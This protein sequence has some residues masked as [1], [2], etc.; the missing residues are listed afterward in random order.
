MYNYCQ[1]A[2]TEYLLWCYN[3]LD[4]VYYIAVFQTIMPAFSHPELKRVCDQLVK[5][6]NRGT[7]AH[8]K[9]CDKLIS[10]VKSDTITSGDVSAVLAH[11]LMPTIVGFL[12]TCNDMVLLD[13]IQ[14]FIEMT[15]ACMKLGKDTGDYR[16]CMLALRSVYVHGGIRKLGTTLRK[17]VAEDFTVIRSVISG[18]VASLMSTLM[19]LPIVVQSSAASRVPVYLFQLYSKSIQYNSNDLN[20]KWQYCARLILHMLLLQCVGEKFLINDTVDDLF[21]HESRSVDML[22]HIVEYLCSA[23]TECPGYLCTGTKQG[24]VQR[25]NFALDEDIVLAN[26][27]IAPTVWCFQSR[28]FRYSQPCFSIGS[29]ITQYLDDVVSTTD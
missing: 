15:S 21:H 3:G 4:F 26:E 7:V 19:L 29:N 1:P 10:I 13:V 6:L 16:W 23:C 5:S 20:D 2:L 27:S 14:I 12:D 9:Y 25:I 11:S 8:S 28:L 22:T 24:F 17:F 18:A